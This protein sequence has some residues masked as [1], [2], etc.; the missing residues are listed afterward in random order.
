MVYFVYYYFQFSSAV[1]YDAL[2]RV[3]GGQVGREP[4]GYTEYTARAQA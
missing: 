4:V 1:R 3:Y 2:W